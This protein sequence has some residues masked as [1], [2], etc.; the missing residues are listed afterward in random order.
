MRTE[1]GAGRAGTGGAAM[2]RRARGAARRSARPGGRRGGR[3]GAWARA[4]LLWLPLASAAC[5]GE[6]RREEAQRVARTEIARAESTATRV[7][8]LPATGLWSA[9]HVLERLV[10]AG[11]APRP[12][13]GAG[14]GPAW[15][16]V[17]PVVY[18]AGGGEV[19]AWIY[20]DSAARRAVTDGLDPA[21]AAPPGT[22]APF[23]APMVFVRQNNLAAVITGGSETN[24]ERVALALQAGLPAAP[25]K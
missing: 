19:W 8:A 24:Q 25:P 23:A 10:R 15:M 12:A 5:G 22:V 4:A 21:T 14:P 2:A 6:A 20:P 16:K 17:A 18:A 1:C 11:V 9:E 3:W 13:E 7:A